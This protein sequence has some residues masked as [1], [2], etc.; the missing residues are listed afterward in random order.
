MHEKQQVGICTVFVRRLA[1][2]AVLVLQLMCLFTV[3]HSVTSPQPPP[4]FFCVCIMFE[5]D[6][7]C[8]GQ[9]ACLPH[10]Y[11][12]SASHA[13][14]DVSTLYSSSIITLSA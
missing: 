1:W 7:V 5:L 13:S 14:L 11:D 8:R 6:C 10:N 3:N 4:P 12:I 9:C 2:L